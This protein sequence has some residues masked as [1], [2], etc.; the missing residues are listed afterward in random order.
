MLKTEQLDPLVPS[1]DRPPKHEWTNHFWYVMHTWALLARSD[2]TDE[3]VEARV[4]LFSNAH[5]GLPCAK[6][7]VH[8]KENFE[9]KPYTRAHAR[10][11]SMGLQWIT[12]LREIIQRGIDAEEAAAAVAGVEPTKT[13]SKYLSCVPTP[14]SHL[15]KEP[16]YSLHTP[17]SNARRQAAIQSALE[18]TR[19]NEKA[20]ADCGCNMR[21]KSYKRSSKFCEL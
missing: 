18:A 12:D 1:S 14:P 7:R 16:G 11:N 8:Y 3:D 13:G 15:F 21:E 4:A 17:S 5:A 2:A 20:K 6:C 10:S 19:A 9:L